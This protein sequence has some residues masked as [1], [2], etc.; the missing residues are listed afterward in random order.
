MHAIHM[1]TDGPSPFAVDFELVE[2]TSRIRRQQG[3][4]ASTP[5]LSKAGLVIVDERLPGDLYIFRSNLSKSTG[6]GFISAPDHG[7]GPRPGHLIFVP[8]L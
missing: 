8:P 6:Q 7:T 3:D 5:T 1:V 2:E 4:L